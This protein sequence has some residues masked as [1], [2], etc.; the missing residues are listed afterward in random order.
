MPYDHL[1]LLERSEGLEHSFFPPRAAHKY[2]VRELLEGV[3]RAPSNEQPE[4]E[5]PASKVSTPM[6]TSTWILLLS[7]LHVAADTDIDTM[8]STLVEDLRAGPTGG[9]DL[10][11]LVVA[12]D[13]TNRA[14]NEEFERAGDLI[15]GIT[16]RVPGLSD[17]NIVVVPGNHDLDWSHPDVYRLHR[18][19]RPKDA[20]DAEFITQGKFTI[21]RDR[22]NYA[23][24]F[25]NFSR[26]VYERL[27]GR[28][29]PLDH[30]KQADLFDFEEHGLCFVTFNS[31]W[32]TAEHSPNDPMIVDQAVNEALRKL[33]TIKGERLRIAVWH[34]P[35]SG[36]E[37]IRED[38]FV[39]RL[40]NAGVRLCLH[41]H[42]HESRTDMLGYL[43]PRQL[44][45]IGTGSFGAPWQHRAESTPLL[46]QLIEVRED[47]RSI[48]VHT[49][50][51]KKFGAPWEPWYEWPDP[52]NPGGKLPHFDVSL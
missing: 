25:G 45:A 30:T 50:G 49:R 31:A 5:P 51:R 2:R 33:D 39:E 13:L 15:L 47:R 43:H 23:Q 22:D 17:K 41:G 14:S 27:C 42:I 35:I 7:D 38:A 3:R 12:G 10:A 34:H 16:D 52:D 26:H 36:N 4:R 46:Y 11:A 32:N 20:T 8:M 9:R 24:S 48:R 44:Y 29:Y 6:T 21:L 18:G 1:L 37:K 40:R 28:P 19:P